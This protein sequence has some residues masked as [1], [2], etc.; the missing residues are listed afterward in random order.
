M[1][2]EEKGGRKR[3]RERK[4]ENFITQVSKKFKKIVDP[5]GIDDGIA[6]IEIR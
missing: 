5:D 2:K 1:K 3:E 6:S 4:G